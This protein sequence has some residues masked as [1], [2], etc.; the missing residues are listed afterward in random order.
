IKPNTNSRPT[1]DT[2]GYLANPKEV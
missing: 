1:G 2:T